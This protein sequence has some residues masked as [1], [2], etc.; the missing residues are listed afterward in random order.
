VKIAA[1]TAASVLLAG[2]VAACGSLPFGQRPDAST[3][4]QAVLAYLDAAVAG[5]CRAASRLSTPDLVR[6]GLWCENPRVLSYGQVDEGEQ[7]EGEVQ[8]YYVADAV[9]I[10]GTGLEV[11]GLRAGANSILV[12]VL[13]QADG[14]WRVTRT[15][16]RPDD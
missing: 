10:G 7:L 3:P 4:R 5:D 14:T 9:V 12:E 6:E 1:S 15:V 11:L 8:R 13:P 2:V 16:G